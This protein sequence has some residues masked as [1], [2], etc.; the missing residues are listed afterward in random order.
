MRFTRRQLRG[1]IVETIEQFFTPVN[2]RW[3][4]FPGEPDYHELS[5][6]EREEFERGMQILDIVADALGKS[7]ARKLKFISVL[8]AAYGAAAR[9]K[10]RDAVFNLFEPAGEQEDM[11]WRVFSKSGVR[12]DIR[13][14]ET[15]VMGTIEGRPAVYF[16]RMHGSA[17]RL[18][19]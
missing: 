4:R 19:I 2:T 11:M 14:G 9:S 10:P 18:Y 16:S 15:M 1:L 5:E 3:V 12:P 7:S 8:P 6:E 13:A 17:P